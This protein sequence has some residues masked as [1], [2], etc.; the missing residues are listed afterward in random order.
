MHFDRGGR[1]PYYTRP[2][3]T[4]LPDLVDYA[5]LAQEG[6]VLE[7]VYGLRE[8]PRLKD[9]LAEPDGTLRAS[10]AFVKMPSGGAGARVAIRAEPRLVCQRC[11]QGFAYPVSGGSEIEFTQD[12]RSDSERE[13]FEVDGGMVSLRELAEEELLLALPIAP[14]C[15]KPQNC[16]NAPS[17]DMGATGREESDETRRPFSALQDLLKKTR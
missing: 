14:V 12:E 8:L 4:G 6:A 15:S 2:M 10:F 3:A 1:Q 9:V 17:I 7:R 5:R 13:Y 16:G 11:V